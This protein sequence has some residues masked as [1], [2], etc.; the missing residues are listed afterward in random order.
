MAQDGCRRSQ[1]LKRKPN[2]PLPTPPLKKPSTKRPYR[3]D[4]LDKQKRQIRLFELLPGA[5]DEQLR[6]RLMTADLNTHPVFDALSYVWGDPTPRFTLRIDDDGFL[7]ISENLGNALICLRQQKEPRTLWA[8]AICINQQDKQERGHQVRFMRAVYR[9]AQT[10]RVWLDEDVDPKSKP[11]QMARRLYVPG[12]PINWDVCPG[13][14]NARDLRNLVR[15][16]DFELDFW[17]PL[18]KILNNLYFRRVWTQQELFLARNL[19]FHL[20]GG[21]L[22]PG[23]LIQFDAALMRSIGVF[24][25]T[26]STDYVHKAGVPSLFSNKYYG[27]LATK[28][29]SFNVTEVPQFNQ[30]S[31]LWLFLRSNNLEATDPKDRV[32]G[33]LGLARDCGENDILPDYNLGQLE[34]YSLEVD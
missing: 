19:L 2:S 22:S 6:G 8:D 5:K 24:K 16:G 28:V 30:A 7:E 14:S 27:F 29:P 21:T 9:T 31:L 34:T 3:Y 4:T 13:A 10:V 1:R 20:P 26:L 33:M 15:V 18:S 32:Y 17:E 12:R 11:F 25:G 23:P